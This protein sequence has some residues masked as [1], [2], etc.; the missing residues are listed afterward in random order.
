[1]RRLGAITVNS[2]RIAL[3]VLCSTVLTGGFLVLGGTGVTPAYAGPC[4]ATTVADT[5]AFTTCTGGSTANSLDYVGSNPS[6]PLTGGPFTLTLDNHDVS[7]GSNGDG[8]GFS[9]V[10]GS[11]AIGTVTLKNGSDVA[12]N[13]NGIS[14]GA[15]GSISII[16]VNDTS[17][18]K[19]GLTGIFAQSFVAGGDITVNTQAGTSVEG[20]ADGAAG[21]G[22]FAQAAGNVKV[23][24]Q[25]IV[26]SGTNSTA[27]IVQTSTGTAE[28]KTGAGAITGDVIGIS[29]FSTGST[30][31]VTTGAGE[32]KA[33]KNA[34]IF[35][36]SSVST[37]SVTTG[38]G[39]VT[40][41]EGEG[42][43]ATS[44][45]GATID[46]HGDVSG[47]EGISASTDSGLLKITTAAGK[48]VTGTAANGNGISAN[49]TSGN[50]EV[51]ANSAVTG[52][53][54]GITAFADGASGTVSVTTG[55]AAVKANNGDGVFA[56]G[57]AK[58]TV[59]T[60]GDVT[61]TNGT[62]IS[63]ASLGSA[64]IEV[65]TKGTDLNVVRG[66]NGNGINALTA[67][68]GTV[69]ITNNVTASGSIAGIGA[70][71]GTGAIEI[72]NNFLVQNATGSDTG[73][74]IRTSGGPATITNNDRIIGVVQTDAS[75]D[76]LINNGGGVW[77]TEGTSDFRGGNDSV[78]NSGRII[79]GG[80][81][82]ASDATTFRNLEL[83][84]NGGEIT[85]S[86]QMAGDGNTQFDKLETSG[87]YRGNLGRLD[88]DVFL[89]G[90]GSQ[91]DVFV[92]GGK[93][94][95]VTGIF[96]TDTNPGTG[97]YNP[98]GILVVDAGA[99]SEATAFVLAGGPIQKGLFIY[100]L[101]FDAANGE[102]RL[103]SLPGGDILETPAVVSGS[104]EIWRE[105]SDAWST[106]QENLRD[107]LAHSPTVTAVA[108]P[109]V[110]EDK[111][112]ASLWASALGSWAERDHSSS[113]SAL[114]ATLEFD[115]SYQQ[116]IYGVVGGADFGTG[117]G[118][119]GNLLF[120]VMGGYV[121]SK[122]DFDKSAT[123][124][125]TDGATVGAY[126]TLLD[127]GFFA[128]VLVKADL[129]T[130]RYSAGGLASDANDDANVTSI[131][132]R[133]DIGYRFGDTFFVE[134]VIS[135][136]A[137]STKIDRF[138]IGGSK[139]DAGTNDSFRAGAGLRAGYGD[140]TIRAS[141][142][143][144]IWDEFSTDNQVDIISGGAPLGL[145]DDDM[146]GVYGDVSGQV[147][148]SLSANATLYLKGGILF[149]EDVSKPNASGGL[150]V[151]W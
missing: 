128:S 101:A 48:T 12:S 79:A 28:V 84:T 72:I 90:A 15:D 118:G 34:A 9:G 122:L 74:A 131:G 18:V 120:G 76:K 35:A 125:D 53:L 42:I 49:A 104:Q 33:T 148:V 22:A 39:A 1:M 132:G 19:G 93:A 58:V 108:D 141:A 121:D 69:K 112:M 47:I 110:V 98:T 143:A 137:L 40:S 63:A 81:A 29:A 105:T 32:V 25:G 134:P 102:Y 30:A 31:T 66:T 52:N 64:N 44:K 62:G 115:T 61:G 46:A 144:R 129:L 38:T 21:I 41:T 8:I 16:N 136:D 57:G 142:T 7:A 96:I 87:D 10:T 27:I 56:R 119:G 130:L 70:G 85:L 114:N 124:I 75:A 77:R 3:R 113:V 80:N 111:P 45:T 55:T 94:E 71:S 68:T 147:D 65:T 67:G 59:E 146:E 6:Y 20:T 82:N 135:A 117:I 127:R 36:K 116:N 50:T 140:E 150:A 97:V 91:G 5:A 11:N 26:S 92:I 106:R 86:D 24:A 60:N 4:T 43:L 54:N 83:L 138:E 139:I 37:V 17:T 145:S 14:V 88:L 100:D 133:G 149:S 109:P 107:R 95:G 78:S 73:V 89:G 103:V 51:T 13:S 99:A 2:T 151:Y 126:A 23:D 123:S